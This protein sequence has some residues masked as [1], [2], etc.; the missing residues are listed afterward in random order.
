MFKRTA[1]AF[2]VTAAAGLVLAGCSSSEGEA[3]DEATSGSDAMAGGELTLAVFNGWD[4]SLATS[5][6][7]ENILESKGYTVELEYADPAVV[8][9]G[10][11]DGDYDIV[12][13]VW[14]PLTHASY[15]EEF[16]DDMEELGAWFDS[17]ALTVAVNADAPID[18]LDELA[19]N[20]DAFG[21]RIVG[22]EPGAGLTATVQ[23]A[24]IPTYGLEGLD[25]ITSST[26]AM[27]SELDTATSNGEN[28]IVTLWEP[29]W[30]YGA[31]DLKNLEDPEGTL[32][33]AESIVTY[34][35]AGISEDHPE[36]AAW[37]GAFTMDADHLY[38]LENQLNGQ[39]ASDYA[40]IVSEWVAANQEWVDS[41]TA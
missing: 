11:A 23:D 25:F 37:L 41:L 14:L 32:G 5:L 24:V 17:A 15:I 6:L 16:G 9:Q 8:F 10:V 22:I 19:D 33:E 21:N 30:A 4:E 31:Y 38:D 27:L 39:D 40:D 20:A 34:G 26:P 35:R 29:H 36:V 2:A 28:I 18:S 1:T 13:D 7:W 3:A 12:T